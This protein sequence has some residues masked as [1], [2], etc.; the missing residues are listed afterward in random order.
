MRGLNCVGRTNMEKRRDNLNRVQNKGRIFKKG[1]SSFLASKAPSS[2]LFLKIQKSNKNTQ[3]Q[4]MHSAVKGEMTVNVKTA[5]LEIP[6]MD[7]VTKVTNKNAVSST[8][9]D[10]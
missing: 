8:F 6:G 7:C 3:V 5:D 10:R 2:V 1:D 9:R 4:V